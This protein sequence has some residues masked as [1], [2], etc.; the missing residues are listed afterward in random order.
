MMRCKC[1][2]AVA[3]AS[4]I[5]AVSTTSS[6][7]QAQVEVAP[8]KVEGKVAEVTEKT[9]RVVKAD[10]SL[11]L[12]H[13]DPTAN[14]KG[15]APGKGAIATPTIQVQGRLSPQVL[16]TPGLP[17]KI[18]TELNESG[19]P[20]KEVSE[21]L[22]FS[23]SENDPLGVRP[24]NPGLPA[25]EVKG[26]VTPG[27]YVVAGNTSRLS[28]DSLTLLVP[29]KWKCKLA[30]NVQVNLKGTDIR[31][32]SLGDPV[33]VDAMAHDQTE[34]WGTNVKI[35]KVTP[36]DV[37]EADKLAAANPTEPVKEPP[38]DGG[39]KP[40]MNPA[41]PLPPVAQPDGKKK[42]DKPGRILTIN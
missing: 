41:E 42:R 33:T 16:K 8:F 10:G 34:V 23:P 13:L 22:V 6:H 39:V 25:E 12:V 2:W 28:K 30:D 21:V 19:N 24:G 9:L 36:K 15:V 40:P 1:N 17:V 26:K 20:V 31:F 35:T 7:S 37:L 32:A 18:T 38:Q 27:V 14:I 5:L 3:I 4:F 29:G 11:V